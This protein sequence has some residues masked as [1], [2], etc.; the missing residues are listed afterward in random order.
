MMVATMVPLSLVIAT[1]FY[2][3]LYFTFADCFVS[4][5]GEAPPAAPGR[6]SPPEET[7]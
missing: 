2:A 7:S 6:R 1:M 3:S 5:H 4:S